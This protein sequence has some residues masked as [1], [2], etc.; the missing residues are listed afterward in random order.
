MLDAKTTRSYFLGPIFVQVFCTS[1]NRN[2]YVIKHRLS[3]DSSCR[4]RK[5]KYNTSDLNQCIYL[6]EDNEEA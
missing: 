1:F 4:T 3:G 2:T 5:T 6:S